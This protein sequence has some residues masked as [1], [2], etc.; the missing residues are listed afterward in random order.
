[1]VEKYC[2]RQTPL[3]GNNTVNMFQRTHNNRN[4]VLCRSVLCSCYAMHA[5][6]FPPPQ[7]G[8]TTIGHP[9]WGNG[10]IF[11]AWSL[12]K[13]YKKT[14]EASQLSPVGASYCRS[15]FREFTVEGDKE[16]ISLCQEDLL[17]DLRTLQ[18]L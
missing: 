12:P 18:V 5:K 3:L 6:H 1:V 8:V 15:E 11:Y 16:E 4:S 14:V 13:G 2:D 17:C 7:V 9:L 10:C